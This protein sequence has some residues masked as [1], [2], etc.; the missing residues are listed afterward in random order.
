MKLKIYYTVLQPVSIRIKFKRN[1]SIWPLLFWITT[2][3]LS[4]KAIQEERSTFSWLKAHPCCNFDFILSTESWGVLQTC[5]SNINHKEKF[6]GF[7]SEHFEVHSS[8]LRKAG[9]WVR[10]QLWVSFE[11]WD[12]AKYC[13]SVHGA[14]LKWLRAHVSS[15]ASKISEIQGWLLK[16]TP[17]DTTTRKQL[18]W[19]L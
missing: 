16:F 8:L 2:S 14:P 13:W 5:L 19:S 3:D 1:Y 10:I 12:G 7:K 18:D 15:S 9:V 11:L 6:R 17:E 4:R